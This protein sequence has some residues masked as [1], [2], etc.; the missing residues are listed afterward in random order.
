M[1]G[2]I[3]IPWL[4]VHGTADDVVLIG[5]SETVFDNANNPKKLVVIN[6]A[7]HVFSGSAQSQMVETVVNWIVEQ[8]SN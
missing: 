2:Q 8:K 6:D 1:A 7:D 3:R 5:D 4:L